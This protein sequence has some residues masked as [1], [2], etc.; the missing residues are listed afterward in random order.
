MSGDSELERR[1]G[2]LEL[3]GPRPE[4]RDEIRRG[5]S[6][7]RLVSPIPWAAAATLLVGLFVATE[8][9]ASAHEARI[10]EIRGAEE[11]SKPA[12]RW[13]AAVRHIRETGGS[14]G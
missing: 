6:R 14:N 13:A 9:K 11:A 2:E 5:L 1:L 4:L 7:F 10:A 8:M 12:L 3:P